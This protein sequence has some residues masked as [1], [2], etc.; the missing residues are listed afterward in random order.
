[1]IRSRHLLGA[2]SCSLAAL[3]A[4]TFGGCNKAKSPWADAKPGQ[5]KVLVSFAPL[6]CFAAGVAGP[7]AFVQPLITNTG[8]HDHQPDNHDASL[9]AGADLF[10]VNGL[11]L[12]EYVTQI[13]NRSGNKKIKIIEVGEDAVPEKDRLRMGDHDEHGH[14]A[15]EAK[16]VQEAK[17]E[18]DQDAKDAKK[19]Q[20]AKKDHGHEHG[21]EHGEWDPHVWLGVDQAILIVNGIRDA[22]KQADPKH[23]EG[24]EQRAAEYVKKLKDLQAY[25]AKQL[26]GKTNRKL[27]ASHESLG[28]FCKAF[29][30]QLVDSIQ[31]RAGVEADLPKLAELEKICKKEDVRV[32]AV[33]PQYP[34]GAAKTLADELEKKGHKIEIIEID[35]L[36]TAP[37][38]ELNADY[39]FVVMRKN[40]DALAKKLP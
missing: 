8:P 34:K 40:I 21:H 1:M 20:P 32:I 7:D 19:E 36:E 30:L 37:A 25:A 9:A 38:N 14:D 16:K 28:Y 15:K 12:D 6:Y 26:E 11:G 24:Y 39:Y 5:L 22:L 27:I 13:A 33:E 29:N 10:L 3:V 35:P 4:L 2:L 17:K 23:A 18:H 31:P